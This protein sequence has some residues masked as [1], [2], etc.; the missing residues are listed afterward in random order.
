[1]ASVTREAGAVSVTGD[2]SGPILKAHCLPV[3]VGKAVG[4]PLTAVAMRLD[5]EHDAFHLV[6]L[7]ADQGAGL[8]FG[9]FAEDDVV[10][11]WRSLG[12]VTGLELKIQLPNG[13]MLSPYPQLGRVLLGPTRH[14]RRHS[15]LANRRPRFLTRRKTGVFWFRPLVHRESELADWNEG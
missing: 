8:V 10:A 3:L 2:G 13:S 14:R 15:L 12:A 9:P 1:M 6:L 4:R 5:R 11:E 7:D